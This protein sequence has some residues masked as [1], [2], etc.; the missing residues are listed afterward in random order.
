ML[1]VTSFNETLYREY[2]ERMVRE[3][4]EHSDGS[5]RLI[6]VFEGDNLPSIALEN[7]EIIRF[8]SKDHSLFLNKFGHLHE[9]RGLRIKALPNNQ[10][11]L[12][13]DYRFDAVR[14]SFKIF[15]IIQTIDTYEPTD[16][17]AWID[18]DISCVK[19]FTATDLVR[20]FPK[21]GDLMSYLGRDNFPPGGAYS[22]CGFLG[23]NL[24]HP[25]ILQYLNRVAL[26]Y[27]DGEIF[28]FEQ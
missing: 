12:S 10:I 4:S 22:E 13:M 25:L 23:F 17:L 16:Y 19:K 18:A 24:K 7:I 8:N 6:V 1:L 15:S 28:S 14:F 9:A 26:I 11:N 5:V 3:F 21:D 20:F 2:G 27:K